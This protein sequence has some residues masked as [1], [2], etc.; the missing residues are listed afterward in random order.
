MN[1][2]KLMLKLHSLCYT[3]RVT[4]VMMSALILV[5]GM[6]KYIKLFDEEYL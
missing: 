6:F 1:D 3:D 2:K 4:R 5:R